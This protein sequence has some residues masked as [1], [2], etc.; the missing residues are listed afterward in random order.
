MKLIELFE[1]LPE[2]VRIEDS[3]NGERRICLTEKEGIP[4]LIGQIY[5]LIVDQGTGRL[6]IDDIE[7][8]FTREY[9]WNLRPSIF[10]CGSIMELIR[11]LDGFLEVI[12][13]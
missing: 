1:A 10:K 8:V 11:K 2:T 12:N 7:R 5:K 3:E 4:A 6:N 13:Y 9:G